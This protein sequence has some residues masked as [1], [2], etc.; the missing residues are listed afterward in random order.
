[1]EWRE[2][3]G[4]KSGRKIVPFTSLPGPHLRD[5]CFQFSRPWTREV[6]SPDS[7]EVY[8]VNKEYRRGCCS[9]TLGSLCQW[10][11]EGKASRSLQGALVTITQQSPEGCQEA[12]ASSPGGALWYF[13]LS[14]NSQWFVEQK[15]LKRDTNHG[16]SSSQDKVKAISED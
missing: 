14:N 6:R 4:E 3:N 12:E 2:W 7:Q 15:A 10:N 16:F 1:M 5:L 11:C 9:Y 13:L 8:P